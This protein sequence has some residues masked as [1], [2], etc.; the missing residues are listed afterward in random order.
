[1][2]I[3]GRALAIIGAVL[4]LGAIAVFAIFQM[5]SSSNLN[6]RTPNGENVDSGSSEAPVP[7]GDI[8]SDFKLEDAFTGQTVSLS[9]LKGKVVFL[10]VWAT[11]C[12]PCREEMP[13][14]ETLYDELKSNKDFVML[15][16]SQDTKGKSAVVPYVEK[17]GYHFKILL[18]PENKVGDSYSVSGV[19]ET[20]II[21]R[22]GRIVAHHMGAFDWSRPDVKEALRQLLSDKSG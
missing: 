2:E 6:I 4:A 19:P 8:A 9:S 18:D 16:V 13:S 14:M 1:M 21:D 20:F 3:K 15:A 11:W 5:M 7:A 17:N 10:N 12:G 22:K